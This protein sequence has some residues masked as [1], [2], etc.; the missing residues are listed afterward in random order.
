MSSGG[1]LYHSSGSPL[2]PVAEALAWLWRLG[3]PCDAP[4][5]AAVGIGESHEAPELQALVRARR[6]SGAV[7]LAAGSADEAAPLP[8]RRVRVGVARIGSVHVEGAHTLFAGGRAVVRSS[9]GVH[10]VRSGDLLA[11][12]ADPSVWGRLDL[13]W[14]LEAIASFLVERLGR[15]LVLLPPVGCLRLDDFPGTAELQLRGAAKRDSRQRRQAETMIAQ[16]ERAQARLVVAA[17]A[18]ALAGNAEAPLDRVWPDAVAEL[19]RGVDRGVLE[20]ACHGLL[21]LEPGAR[22]EGRVDPREFAH[23]DASAAGDRIDAACAWLRHHLGDPRSFVAP[24]WAYGPGA[25]AAATERALPS[26]L[27]PEPAPL[28]SGL[29]LH[30]TLAIG[31][32]GLHGVDYTPLQRLA[33]I[34]LPPTVVFHGRLL[35][36]RLPRL[37]SER[38]LPTALR[39]AW[40]RDLE[41]LIGL[42]GLRWVGASELL[43]QLRAHDAIEA[44]DGK[45]DAE[46]VASARLFYG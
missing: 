23:L 10:A 32:P 14:V 30:E 31:L 22:E 8:F 33:A 38:D 40:K 41:R 4:E 39:L 6:L 26:W 35:D 44:E 46:T 13:F 43:E 15:P 5:A 9:L 7:I 25:L 12:G 34:G 24:A 3:P 28:L 11:I 16:L 2:A 21:H 37:R 18:C 17:P 27:P 1:S 42:T 29:T 36:D 19:A 45:I 20:P